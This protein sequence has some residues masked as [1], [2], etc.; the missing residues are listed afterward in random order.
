MSRKQNINDVVLGIALEGNKEIR[1]IVVPN[2]VKGAKKV[3]LGV[4]VEANMIKVYGPKHDVEMFI[5]CV[6]ELKQS[7]E[8]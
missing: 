2:I 4:S 1:D 3:G 7:L 8:K 5:T 6:N